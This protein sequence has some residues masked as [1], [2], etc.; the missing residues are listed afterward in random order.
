M[1][2]SESRPLLTVKE[3]AERLRYSEATVLRRIRD[4][5]LRAIVDGRLIRIA[6]EDLAAFIR[7]SRRWR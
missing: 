5:K 3:A 6:P 4:G 1:S 2:R 7:A